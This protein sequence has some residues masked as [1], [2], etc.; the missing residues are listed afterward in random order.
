MSP[1]FA[2]NAGLIELTLVEGIVLLVALRE[3][4]SVRRSLRSKPP[5]GPDRPP[6]IAESGEDEAQRPDR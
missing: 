1:F 3:L 4:W 5:G 6:E 2:R